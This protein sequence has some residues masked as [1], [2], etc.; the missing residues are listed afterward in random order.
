MGWWA[1]KGSELQRLVRCTCFRGYCNWARSLDATYCRMLQLFIVVDTSRNPSCAAADFRSRQEVINPRD[2]YRHN[3]TFLS[4]PFSTGNSPADVYWSADYRNRSIV[5]GT[6]M[7]RQECIVLQEVGLGFLETFVSDRRPRDRRH[8]PCVDYS[9]KD[10]E[11]SS[12]ITQQHESRLL[13]WE[14]YD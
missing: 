11:I 10:H 9:T 12:N 3:W 5:V 6:G 4:L 13:Y 14:K 2:E 8:K 1:E 7:A